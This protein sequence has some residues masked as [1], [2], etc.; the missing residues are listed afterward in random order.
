[1]E[2]NLKLKILY[3]VAIIILLIGIVSVSAAMYQTIKIKSTGQIKGV[4]CDIFA[5][6]EGV[7]EVTNL[8]WGILEPRESKNITVYVKN[9][10][11][12]PASLSMWTETWIPE[13]AEIYVAFVWNYEGMTVPV[14]AMAKVTF[15][16]TIDQD[17]TGIN[18]F[19]FN[20]WIL[21]EG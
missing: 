13:E 4:G 20:I 8:D 6:P 7:I 12:V 17:I 3:A 5:D 19:S 2:A 15:T 11:N 1:M 16:L 18:M 21:A 14:D 9:T 10:G